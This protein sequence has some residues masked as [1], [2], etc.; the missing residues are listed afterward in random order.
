[1][2]SPGFAVWEVLREEE[3]SP[4]KN[5]DGAAK[6][7]P[8]TSREALLDLHHRW[9]IKAGGHFTRADGSIIADIPR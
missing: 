5:A 2:N 8:T 4:L 1:V 7:T 6:D 3:F 9:V